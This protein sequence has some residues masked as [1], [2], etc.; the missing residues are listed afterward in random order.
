MGK[1]SKRDMAFRRYVRNKTIQR[2]S[3]WVMRYMG[4][5]GINMMDSIQREK[6]IVVVACASL[7][8]SMD[9]QQ[10]KIK[11]KLQEKSYCWMLIIWINEEI[12]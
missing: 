4:L 7:E 8:K 10:L 11:E 6:Y 12:S 1:K 5:I 3:I 9:C 2:K